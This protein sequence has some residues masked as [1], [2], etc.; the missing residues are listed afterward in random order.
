ME[1]I[2]GPNRLNLRM[3]GMILEPPCLELYIPFSEM[4]GVGFFI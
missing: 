3:V 4:P 1:R 2:Q